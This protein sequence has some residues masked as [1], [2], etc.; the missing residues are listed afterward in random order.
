[1]IHSTAIISPEAE[2]GVGVHIGPYTVI[3]GTVRIGDNSWIG[4]HVSIG[5]V[6]EHST[7]RYELVDSYIGKGRIEIGQR[8]CIRE[9]TTVNQ[10]MAERTVIGDDCY[11]MARSHVAHDCVLEDH[12]GLSTNV[13]LG[14][15]TYL[16]SHVNMGLGSITHQL[17][18]IGSYAMVAANATVVKD[19]P[20]LA[21]F[22]PGKELGYHDYAVNKFNLQDTEEYKAELQTRWSALR[23]DTRSSY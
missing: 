22:I 4:P 20:P 19:I 13:C 18:T 12:V 3:A 8:V 17:T 16:M 6:P 10:P 21:K 15:W 1:M 23:R 5:Q 2:I 11:I 7:N 9:F 14:G